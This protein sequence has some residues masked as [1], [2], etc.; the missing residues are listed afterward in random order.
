MRVGDQVCD[1]H[2]PPPHPPGPG[3]SPYLKAASQPQL[4]ARLCAS[5]SVWRQR[6]PDYAEALEEP[7]P[8]SQEPSRPTGLPASSPPHPQQALPVPIW[9]APLSRTGGVPGKTRRQ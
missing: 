9:C 4:P 7:E 8:G 2:L 1:P 3:V 5:P 6:R